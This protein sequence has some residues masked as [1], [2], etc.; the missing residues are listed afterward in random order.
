MIPSGPDSLFGM[1]SQESLGVEWD[2]TQAWN[3]WLGSLD[4]CGRQVHC[5]GLG[6]RWEVS[7]SVSAV[8]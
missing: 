2:E 1:V 6:R 8:A 4:M 3:L 5:C 7:A